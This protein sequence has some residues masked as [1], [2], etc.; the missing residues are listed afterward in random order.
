MQEVNIPETLKRDVAIDGNTVYIAGVYVKQSGVFQTFIRELQER[1]KVAF[2]IK[3]DP[4]KVKELTVESETLS[5]EEVDIYIRQLIRYAVGLRVSDV[6]LELK[7]TLNVYMRVNGMLTEARTMQRSRSFGERV[8]QSLFYK[9]EGASHVSYS[10]SEYLYGNMSRPEDLTPELE[11]IRLQMGPMRGGNFCVMRFLYSSSGFELEK[12]SG[13]EET[14]VKTFMKYGYKEESIRKIKP[15][16]EGAEGLTI[17]SGP[18]GSGKSTAIK[19]MLELLH[20]LYPTKSIFTIEN[21][22][23]YAIKGAKQLPVMEGQTF[24]DVLRIALRSD[25]DVI[26]VGEVRETETAKTCIDAVLTGH[27]VF[28]TIHARDTATILERLEKLGVET[29]VLLENDLLKLLVSQRLV[30]ANCPHCLEKTEAGGIYGYRSKGCAKC[31][32]TGVS[33]RVVVEEAVDL[34]D[35]KKIGEATSYRLR[36]YLMDRKISLYHRGLELVKAS[37]IS[38]ENLHAFVGYLHGE[39][40]FNT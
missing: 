20:L 34:T 39:I 7:D 3:I 31:G 36:Q 21:P 11:G 4:V 8:L 6:H 15:V 28:T 5:N 35:L 18:T 40:L 1:K 27:Q 14:F 10:L 24:A 37:K 23:E 17:I 38:P 25:P 33:G 22:P 9:S 2:E 26:M 29:G 12:G 16:V 30:P 13:F 32:G 19:L